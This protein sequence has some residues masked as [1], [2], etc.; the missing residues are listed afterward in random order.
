MRFKMK[1]IYLVW[2]W[3]GIVLIDMYTCY[4]NFNA[5]SVMQLLLAS[6]MFLVFCVFWLLKYAAKNA[7]ITIRKIT[8]D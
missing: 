3:F 5:I 4:V 7:T 8:E 1:I 2:L 6:H